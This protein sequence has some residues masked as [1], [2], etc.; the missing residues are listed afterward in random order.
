MHQDVVHVLQNND[1]K[2]RRLLISL[3]MKDNIK[4][5][6][7]VTHMLLLSNKGFVPHSVILDTFG[8][9]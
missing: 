4:A 6:L 1:L 2:I 5:N 8:R 3:A 7:I 9:S